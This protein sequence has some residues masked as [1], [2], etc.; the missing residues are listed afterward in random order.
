M[1]DKNIKGDPEFENK[2]R[3]KMKELSSNVDCFDKISAR[4]FP[5]KDSDFSDSEFTVSDLENV[6]GKHRAAPVLKW[7]AA[8]AAVVICVGVLPKTAFVQEFMTGLR[9]GGD[10]KYRQLVSEILSETEEHTYDIYDMPLKDYV[11]SDILVDPL[12][13]SPFEESDDD[14]IRVR[15]FVRTA[16]PDIF[17]DQVYAVEYKGEFGRSSIL[18]AAESN[19]KYSDKEFEELSNDYYFMSRSEAQYAADRHFTGDK[20]GNML[21][22][23]GNIVAAASFDYKCFIKDGD[24]IRAV[25]AQVLYSMGENSGSNYDMFIGAYDDKTENYTAVDVPDNKDMWKCSINFDGTSAMPVEDVGSFVR[26]DYF[27]DISDSVTSESMAYYLP[28]EDAADS[29]LSDGHTDLLE[30]VP[31]MQEKTAITAPAAYASKC[32]MQVYIP[33]FNFFLY[34][35]DSNA[36]ILI[37]VEGI[38]EEIRIHRSDVI[39]HIGEND[40]SSDEMEKIAAENEKIEAEISKQ[41]QKAQ[42]VYEQEQIRKYAEANS[43]ESVTVPEEFL[44]DPPKD[45]AFTFTTSN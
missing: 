35:S 1:K 39:D 6:T 36:K 23:D 29:L 32:M 3:D 24:D 4:A 8:A 28:F 38:D 14:E 25:T 19:S 20:Y 16:A 9:K 7:I 13:R 11:A 37:K 42:E 15:F 17:T 5:E 2:L 10:E 12:Y 34:S 43:I 21:D 22:Q 40:I 26:K 33:P 30:I 18:A 31:D 44:F 41:A 45:P 27:S